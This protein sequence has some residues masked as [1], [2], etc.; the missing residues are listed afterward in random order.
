MGRQKTTKNSAPTGFQVTPGLSEND[1]LP[2]ATKLEDGTLLSV[3][4]R[5]MMIHCQREIREGQRAFGK[6]VGEEQPIEKPTFAAE[7]NEFPHA[8]KHR[9]LKRLNGVDDTV[10]PNPNSPEAE[11]EMQ[12]QLRLQHQLKLEKQN[13]LESTF[14]PKPGFSGG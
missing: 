9:Y 5:A 12:N 14:N 2:L 10:I 3:E 13:R 1:R 7:G 6:Y 8:K 4:D 11:M